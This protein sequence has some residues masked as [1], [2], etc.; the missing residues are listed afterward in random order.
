LEAP[1]NTQ[2]LENK[3][4]TQACAMGRTNNYKT[5]INLCVMWQ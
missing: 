1:E 4:E 2:K 5:T 3:Q